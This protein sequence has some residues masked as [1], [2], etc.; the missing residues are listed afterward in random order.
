MKQMKNHRKWLWIAVLTLICTCTVSG[1]IAYLTDA[2]DKV[3]NTF[4]P[5]THNHELNEDFTNN[6]KSAVSVKNT[7]ELPI[8]VRVALVGNW[9]LNG[10]IVAPWSDTEITRYST[11]WFKCASDGYWYFKSPLQPNSS[12]GYLFTDAYTVTEEDAPVPGANLVMDVIS[13]SIQ[14]E[15][16]SAVQDAWNV[17]V[18]DDKTI[19][20]N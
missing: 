4:K 17:T 16:E 1:T 12:T 11:N 7:G 10:E 19:I 14:A 5:V 9:Y 15:P 18:A 20:L 3:E 6:V 2:T 13:Q 8:Y